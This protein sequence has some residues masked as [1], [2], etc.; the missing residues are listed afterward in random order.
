MMSLILGLLTVGIG[1]Y[2]ISLIGDPCVLFKSLIPLSFVCGGL[3]AVLAGI[4]S[5]KK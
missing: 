4:S 1:A 2:G 3:L 5:L